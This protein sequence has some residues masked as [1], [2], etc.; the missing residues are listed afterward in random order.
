MNS[1]SAISNNFSMINPEMR[2]AALAESLR[3]KAMQAASSV[4]VNLEG[5]PGLEIN[6]ATSNAATIAEESVL[7]F[8]P[9]TIS[10]SSL[11]NAHKNLDPSRVASLLGLD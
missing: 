7:P 3:E 11:E 9:S 5:N 4:A 6:A 2:A 10:A 1:I 8:N